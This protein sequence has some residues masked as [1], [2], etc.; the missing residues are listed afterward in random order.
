MS[1]RCHQQKCRLPS[2]TPQCPGS[3]ARAAGCRMFQKGPSLQHGGGGQGLGTGEALTTVSPGSAWPGPP[4][5][6]SPHGRCLPS[7]CSP[8]APAPQGPLATSPLGAVPALSAEPEPQGSWSLPKLPLGPQ[9]WLQMAPGMTGLLGDVRPAPPR[10]PLSPRVVLTLG[11][12]P[13]PTRETGRLDVPAVSPPAAPG[14][15]G[16]SP[17]S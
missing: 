13:A 10:L 17:L 5:R 2:R 6:S 7:S 8:P 9:P 3:Q 11:C 14:P 1:A 15:S 4:G 12:P 16:R